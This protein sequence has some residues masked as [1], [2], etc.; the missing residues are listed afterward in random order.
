MNKKKKQVILLLS[1]ILVLIMINY[2]FIDNTL[3][4][5]FLDYEIANVER[6]IDG[7]TIVIENKTSV[8]LLGINCPEKGEKYYGEAK[9]FVEELVLNKSIKLKFGKEK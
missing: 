1:L 2:S 9:E 4:N 8:R 6:V 7:D 5:F 3:E